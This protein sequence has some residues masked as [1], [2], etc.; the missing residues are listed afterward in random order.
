MQKL[1][2]GVLNGLAM[3]YGHF[4]VENAKE[5]IFKHVLCELIILLENILMTFWATDNLANL[6]HPLNDLWTSFTMTI[7]CF[8]VTSLTMKI[9]FYLILHPW[10]IL[11]RDKS[12][13]NEIFFFANIL[14][15]EGKGI[16]LTFF[17]SSSES[18]RLLY[19][20]AQDQRPANVFHLKEIDSEAQH[21]TEN[22]Q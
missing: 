14:E 3:I 5:D 20:S 8:Y 18:P 17:A 19:F 22:C 21:N 15:S 1:Q 7:W 10:A 4:P 11:I 2:N 13:F 9:A 12:T 6:Q 16:F